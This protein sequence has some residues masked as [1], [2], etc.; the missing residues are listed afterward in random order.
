MKPG[1]TAVIFVSKRAA[2]DAEGYAKAAAQMVNQ[3]KKPM[4]IAEYTASAAPMV[5]ELRS[6]TGIAM[7]RQRP[8]KRMPHIPQFARKA[9]TVGTN[10]T[11]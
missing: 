9:A 10:G 7:T 2:A 11:S 6:V 5:S 4:G 8:G 3:Q 1:T